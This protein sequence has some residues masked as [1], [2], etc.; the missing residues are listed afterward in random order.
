MRSRDTPTIEQRDLVTES[1]LVYMGIVG[2]H[3]AKVYG[4]ERDR[5]E[6]E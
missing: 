1:G 2:V 5:A 3:N 4:A 6:S